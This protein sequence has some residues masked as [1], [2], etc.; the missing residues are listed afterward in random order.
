M[1]TFFHGGHISRSSTSQVLTG[2]N[3][4]CRLLDRRPP[5]VSRQ[6]I[7]LYPSSKFPPPCLPREVRFHRKHLP[8]QTTR[9]RTKKRTGEAVRSASD[10][11]APRPNDP[12]CSCS[13]LI[14]YQL[15]TMIYSPHEKGKGFAKKVRIAYK[16]LESFVF[17]G[18][19]A[20]SACLV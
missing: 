14:G 1:P 10:P 3:S 15:R 7:P 6:Q 2:R 16:I 11:C 4:P 13:F 18:V 12:S 5:R 8:V 9:G 19:F 20:Q 17:D